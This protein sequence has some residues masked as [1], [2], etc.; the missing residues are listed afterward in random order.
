MVLRNFLFV[1]MVG[2]MVYQHKNKMVYKK[3]DE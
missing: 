2:F 3:T 1:L